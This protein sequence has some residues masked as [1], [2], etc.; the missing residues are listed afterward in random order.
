MRTAF[1]YFAPAGE[2][3]VTIYG[4]N[5]KLLSATALVDHPLIVN[6][7]ECQPHQ[8]PVKVK[9][10]ERTRFLRKLTDLPNLPSG[11][12]KVINPGRDAVYLR[13][14]LEVQEITEPIPMDISGADLE[15]DPDE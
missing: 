1:D 12:V 7:V 5:L 9:E 14:V 4:P 6:G 13:V 15:P 8:G 11:K 3:E 2:S 10:G